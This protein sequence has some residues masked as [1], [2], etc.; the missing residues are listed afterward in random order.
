M[1]WAS[2]VKISGDMR[3]RYED[4]QSDVRGVRES[5]QRIRARLALAARVNADV[6]AG[7]RLVTSGGR[8]SSNQD[9][10]GGFVGKSV[11]FDRAFIICHPSFSRGTEVIAVKIPHPWYSL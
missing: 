2:R 10:E 6:D 8:T 5:R 11:F 4:K 7:F 9:L 3:V 1:D